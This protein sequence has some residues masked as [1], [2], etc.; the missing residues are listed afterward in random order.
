M[1]EYGEIL[2]ETHTSIYGKNKT[3]IGDE[4]SSVILNNIL[5]REVWNGKD[6]DSHQSE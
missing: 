2:H 4:G 1:Y 5:G 3:C 6:K